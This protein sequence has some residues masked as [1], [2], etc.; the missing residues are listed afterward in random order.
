MVQG[1]NITIT[2]SGIQT[3]GTLLRRVRDICGNH[4]SI[5]W[6]IWC[7]ERDKRIKILCSCPLER[8]I[9]LPL[10]KTG[11]ICKDKG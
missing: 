9:T 11:S 3:V 7:N 1:D 4:W 6:G 10:Y 8:E 5:D 2:L